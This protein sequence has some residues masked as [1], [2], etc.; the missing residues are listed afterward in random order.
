MR[1]T[2]NGVQNGPDDWVALVDP[3]GQ[4]VQFLSY[5]GAITGGDGPAAGVTSQN[6]PVSESNSSAVGSS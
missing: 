1:Y 4:L 6:L 5:E 2:S 3:N